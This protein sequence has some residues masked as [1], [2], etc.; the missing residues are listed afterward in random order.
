M[1]R[2]Y[3]APLGH[4]GSQFGIVEHGVDRSGDLGGAGI[5]EQQACIANR[6]GQHRCGPGHDGKPRSHRLDHRHAKALVLAETD[7]DVSRT[8]G[9]D[10]ILVRHRTGEFDGTGGDPVG[11]DAQCVLVAGR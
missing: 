4:R 1:R 2:S 3:P 7:E 5:R 6:F 11:K 10:K 9:R 8:V